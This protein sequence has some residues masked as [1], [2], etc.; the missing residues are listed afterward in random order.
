[1]SE[2]SSIRMKT[3]PSGERPYRSLMISP[4]RIFAQ[5]ITCYFKSRSTVNIYDLSLHKISALP[6]YIIWKFH[7]TASGHISSVA[8]M[9]GLQDADVL[10]FCAVGLG[11]LIQW[12][13][14]VREMTGQFARLMLSA[15]CDSTSNHSAGLH[16][17]CDWPSSTYEPIG[18]YENDRPTAAVDRLVDLVTLNFD[19]PNCVINKKSEVASFRYRYAASFKV[20][21]KPTMTPNTFNTKLYTMIACHTLQLF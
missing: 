20:P 17:P 19:Q 21:Q 3:A 13:G 4:S 15:R 9:V 1:M 8:F 12:T 16:Q 6:P 2:C 11:C 7:D 10:F 14:Q 5:N 18:C